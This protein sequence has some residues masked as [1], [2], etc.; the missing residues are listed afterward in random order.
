MPCNARTYS[1]IFVCSNNQPNENISFVLSLCLFFPTHSL[2]LFIVNRLDRNAQK[3]NSHGVCSQLVIMC[4]CSLNFIPHYI[5][6]GCGCGCWCE[7][8]M[9]VF[10]THCKATELRKRMYHS[11]DRN[12]T[13]MVVKANH[14]IFHQSFKHRNN[15]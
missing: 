3:M 15:S 7:I 6:Y 14:L 4:L 12:E 8:I 13:T 9:I 2:L 1:K 5:N 10:K 11:D